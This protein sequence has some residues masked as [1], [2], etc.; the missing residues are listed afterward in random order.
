MDSSVALQKL[1][2][3]SL[4]KLMEQKQAQL[5]EVKELEK[6]VEG[7]MNEAW[8]VMQNAIDKEK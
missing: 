3:K 8:A 2:E 4:L 1:D 7:N 6:F 5:D